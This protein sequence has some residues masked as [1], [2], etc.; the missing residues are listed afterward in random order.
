MLTNPRK[1]GLVVVPLMIVAA[2]VENDSVAIAL[3]TVALAVAVVA[4]VATLLARRS[5]R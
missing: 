4:L 5:S 3:S 1:V 2:F